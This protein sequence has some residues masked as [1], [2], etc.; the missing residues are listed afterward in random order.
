[1]FISS[2]GG[3]NCI[4]RDN[5]FVIT[6]TFFC[7]LLI[8]NF[9]YRVM[10]STFE[11][12]RV[13]A[14]DRIATVK[15]CHYCQN[16]V[17]GVTHLMLVEILFHKKFILRVSSSTRIRRSVLACNAGHL[18]SLVF[19]CCLHSFTLCASKFVGL[20]FHCVHQSW[21]KLP[22]VWKKWFAHWQSFSCCN[23]VAR[24]QYT[25]MKFVGL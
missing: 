12:F 19:S 14:R 23:S 6:A 16:N 7:K 8:L 9:Q 3:E 15:K 2:V 21:E 18:V 13:C 25:W 20:C 10:K 17:V 22:P 1:M 24:S 4:V 5:S 11:K